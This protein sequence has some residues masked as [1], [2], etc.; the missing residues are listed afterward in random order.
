MI[1]LCKLAQMNGSAR[2]VLHTY[3]THSSLLLQVNF[4]CFLLKTPNLCSICLFHLHQTSGSQV[5]LEIASHLN[6]T[7]PMH[8]VILWLKGY[9]NTSRMC[10]RNGSI[11]SLIG[12]IT[13]ELIQ[14]MET[15]PLQ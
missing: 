10:R 4:H 11:C 5:P 7:H 3:H 15:A 12:V 1:S 8:T 14:V 9:D 2:F 6:M 13:A